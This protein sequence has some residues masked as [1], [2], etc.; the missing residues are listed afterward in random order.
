MSLS[1]IKQ[2]S[3]CFDLY[4][5]MWILNFLNKYFTDLN[6]SFIVHFYYITKRHFKLENFHSPVYSFLLG[7]REMY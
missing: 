1:P 3:F 7:I 6:V 4:V 5:C 2:K